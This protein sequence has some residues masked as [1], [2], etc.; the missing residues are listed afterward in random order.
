M[1]IIF[2]ATYR[3]K[4]TDELFKFVGATT[5]RMFLEP[6]VGE[7][8]PIPRQEFDENMELTEKHDH[9]NY[10]CDEHDLHTMPHKGCLLR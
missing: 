5:S 3:D 4:R 7:V 2:G 6:E 10:C 8:F 1:M 9:E